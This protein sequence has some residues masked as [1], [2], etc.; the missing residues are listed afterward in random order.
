M[1]NT[2]YYLSCKKSFFSYVKSRLLFNIDTYQLSFL[3]TR[4]FSFGPR[5]FSFPSEPFLGI[6]HS[7]GTVSIDP[8]WNKVLGSHPRSLNKDFGFPLEAFDT[9]EPLFRGVLP[10][11]L[12]A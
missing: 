11:L 4:F 3:C 5:P 7:I 2:N 6:S 10:N 8:V 1:F 9:P 12:G